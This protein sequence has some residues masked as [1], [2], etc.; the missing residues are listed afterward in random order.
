[1]VRCRSVIQSIQPSLVVLVTLLSSVGC[2]SI[3]F[4]QPNEPIRTIEIQQAWQLQPGDRVGNHQ[5]VAGLGDISIH[6]NGGTVYAPFNGQVQPTIQDCVLFSSPEVPAYLFRLCGLN[7][8]KSGEL[9]AG[10]AIGS[11]EYLHFAALRRQPDGTWT[12]VEPAKSL[13]E[14]L[15]R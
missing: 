11:G 1:M 9:L 7:N 13:L 8:P 12:M 4:N 15:M 14:R 2:S 5:I 6:L 3:P 10:S